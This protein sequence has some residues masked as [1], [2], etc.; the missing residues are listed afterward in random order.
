MKRL[1][2]FFYSKFPREG[3]GVTPQGAEDGGGGGGTQGIMGLSPEAEGEGGTVGKS[4]YSGFHRKEQMRR[5]RL[6]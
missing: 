6:V 1:D 2:G 4:L 3:V 5:D